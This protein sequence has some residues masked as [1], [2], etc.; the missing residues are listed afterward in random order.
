MSDCAD[1]TGTSNVATTRLHACLASLTGGARD[2]QR[3]AAK[4]RAAR[5]RNVEWRVGHALSNVVGVGGAVG[6]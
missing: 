1:S 2:E 3:T 4:A 6:E 5:R